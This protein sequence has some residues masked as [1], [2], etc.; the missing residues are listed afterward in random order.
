MS[1]RCVAAS[2]LVALAQTRAA[3]AQSTRD[4]AAFSALVVS[5]VGALPPVLSEPADGSGRGVLAIQF[6][7]WRYDID[8]AIHNNFGVTV[9]KRL[10]S[11]STSV[12]V[13]MAY[14]SLS[15]E[16]SGWASG[17]VAV[18]SAIWS[19]LPA[20]V[21]RRPE[22]HVSLDADV[23]GG[24]F[25]G[26]GHANAYSGAIGVDLGGSVRVAGG[27]RLS[28][29]VIPGLGIGHLNSADVTA[30]GYRP[31]IGA[32]ASWQFRH[33]VALDAGMR[34]IVLRGGPTQFGGG[35]SWHIR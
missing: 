33:G 9:G 6:G 3:A 12:S 34:R 18:R 24:H 26:E 14:L 31:L 35:V 30:T 28:L 25:A 27:S 22:L 17:G 15:C 19:W 10:G 11:S 16:C 5:P 21:E 23:G 7:R 4:L 29:V 8:D 32:A 2:V 13:T 1:A 20:S